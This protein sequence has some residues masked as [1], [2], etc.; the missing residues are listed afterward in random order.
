MALARS[1]ASIAALA[2]FG[3]L[4]VAATI[5]AMIPA[6]Q[7]WSGDVPLL[8]EHARLML[9]GRHDESLILNWYPP[10]ALIPLG[11]PLLAG[12]GPIYASAL[13][14]EMAAVAAI[15]AY[16]VA[17]FAQ[18]SGSTSR[19]VVLYGALVLATA[20]L[21]VW[22]YDILPAVLLLGAIWAVMARRW[23]GGGLALGL[24]TGLKVFAIVLIPVFAVHAWRRGGRTGL[25]RFLGA[26][27][28]V[29]LVALSAY[30]VFPGTTPFDLLA[31]TVNRPLQIETVP[32]SVIAL[33]GSLGIGAVEVS[34]GSFS[35]NLVGEAAAA[36]PGLLRLVQLPV[37]VGTVALGS[38]AVWH[39]SRG[40]DPTLVVA[41]VA[42]LLAMLVTNPVLSTQYVIWALPLVPLIPGRVQI[43]LVGAIGLTALL[44]P[45]LYSGLVALEPLSAAVLVG[46]NGLLLIAWVAAL[47]V[48]VS[49]ARKQTS[50]D[51]HQR[52]EDGGAVVDPE[53]RDAGQAR[54]AGPA[55]HAR[56]AQR[57]GEDRDP[58]EQPQ[59]V[60]PDL[61]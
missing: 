5:L 53:V 13:A 19:R 28:L 24:A 25:A 20:A 11:V 16:F 54:Q 12:S 32:G 26:V 38:I 40:R 60:A 37:L 45:W 23:T 50:N 1:Q 52:E 27:S 31:F 39:S 8:E 34:F 18:E 3:V 41:C 22:R 10:L 51:E 6:A 61:A 21:V 49:S 48:L 57:Q 33:L 15:G 56:P 55:D 43:P 9:N 42:V 14:V 17:R 35:F 58:H 2:T 46:R 4:V 36:A 47:T 29:G 59:P 7:R 44:F 30:L